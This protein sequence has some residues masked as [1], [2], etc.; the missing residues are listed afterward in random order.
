MSDL[1]KSQLVAEF[2][3]EGFDHG[4]CG[5][6]FREMQD[7]EFGRLSFDECAEV[8]TV[9]AAYKTLHVFDC[10]VS[11]LVDIQIAFV[12]STIVGVVFVKDEDLIVFVDTKFLAKFFLTNAIDCSYLDYTIKLFCEFFVVFCK[13]FGFLGRRVH[14]VENP[15]LLASV[16]LKNSAKIKLNDIC[17]L[18]VVDRLLL[19]LLLEMLVPS[20]VEATALAKK[21][22]KIELEIVASK[23]HTFAVTLTLCMLLDALFALL[24]VDSALFWVR[25]HLIRVSNLLEFFF[26]LIGV[27]PIF[28]WV[29]LYCQLLKGS[30]D[31]VF[32]RIWLH[33]HN[34]VVV[35]I[36]IL[37]LLP[38]AATLPAST[39][40]EL[41]ATSTESLATSIEGELELLSRHTGNDKAL[42]AKKIID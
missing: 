24:V 25:E 23:V 31:I 18:K 1:T 10:C 5:L 39:T 37:R 12:A 13:V 8:F 42:S 7:F 19:L 3:R 32:C 4:R 9:N 20:T 36:R 6:L 29:V 40:T 30:F 27:V 34:F 38:L 28:I 15:D 33:T 16:K 35:I 2:L 26:G 14:K 17:L 11:N 41:M 22:V 21:V